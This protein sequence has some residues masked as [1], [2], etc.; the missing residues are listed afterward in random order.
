MTDS[1]DYDAP[2]LLSVFDLAGIFHMRPRATRKWIRQHITPRGGTVRLGNR[3]MVH[4]WALNEALD[5]HIWKPAP[6]RRGK[7]EGPTA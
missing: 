2:H 1:R 6:R 3:I 7:S 5:A 4:T